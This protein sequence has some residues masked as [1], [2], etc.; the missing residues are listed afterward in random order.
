MDF[1]VQQADDLKRLNPAGV[2]ERLQYVAQALRLAHAELGGPHRADRLRGL[3]VDAG[4]FH[5]R[6]RQ[7]RNTSK[8]ATLFHADRAAVRST[9]EK[10]T[11]AITEYLQ[12]QIEAGVDAVQIFDSLGHVLP[13]GEL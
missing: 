11:R 2:A 13:A 7:R 1:A 8:P 12:M 10:L 5:D 4:Q 6:R 9:V 3:A